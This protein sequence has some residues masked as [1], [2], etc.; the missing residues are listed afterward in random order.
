MA[1]T[2]HSGPFGRLAKGAG[3][4]LP[5]RVLRSAAGFYLGTADKE[6]PVSRESMEYWPTAGDAERALA[7]QE[8]E[9]WSQRPN[10]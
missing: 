1:I 8:G 10:F 6:G 4:H 7:G 3:Y 5:L 9:D 2:L